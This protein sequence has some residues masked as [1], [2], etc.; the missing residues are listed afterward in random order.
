MIGIHTQRTL[1]DHGRRFL[2][3]QRKKKESLFVFPY[4]MLYNHLFE[5]NLL[6]NTIYGYYIFRY[7]IELFVGF[8]IS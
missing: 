5:D 7:T 3:E 4:K 8:S 2:N 6:I 1:I